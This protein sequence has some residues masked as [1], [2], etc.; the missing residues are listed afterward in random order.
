MKLDPRWK[1]ILKR[2]W[3]IRLMVLAGVFSGLEVILPIFYS[4][5]PPHMFAL[6]SFLVVCAAFVSRLLA[7]KGLD[8][9]RQ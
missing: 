2:A 9:G 5:I 4:D 8:D 3:S 1:L 7:Q 6:L